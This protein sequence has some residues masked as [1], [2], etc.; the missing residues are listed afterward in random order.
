MRVRC[1]RG[2]VTLTVAKKRAGLCR[3]GP[4]CHYSTNELKEIAIMSHKLN[5]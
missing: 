1:K 5:K 2:V 3:K 4:E